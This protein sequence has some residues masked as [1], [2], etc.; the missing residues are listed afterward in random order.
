MISTEVV[1][2]EKAK[3]QIHKPTNFKSQSCSIA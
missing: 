1:K 3:L 2:F